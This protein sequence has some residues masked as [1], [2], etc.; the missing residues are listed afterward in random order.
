MP[1]TATR[2]A[3]AREQEVLV[4]ERGPQREA[5]QDKCAALTEAA[6]EA[7]AEDSGS[8]SDEGSG[9]DK[10]GAAAAEVV[11]PDGGTFVVGHDMRPSSRPLVE[12]L[13]DVPIVHVACGKYHTAALSADGDV[14]EGASMAWHGMAWRGTAWHG[15]A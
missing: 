4:A 2:A 14:Y 5:A 15:M 7:D 6:A 10:A 1:P 9:D 3:A 12:A 8:G 13:A 11:L